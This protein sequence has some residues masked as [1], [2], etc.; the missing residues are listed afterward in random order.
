MSTNEK[1][2]LRGMFVGGFYGFCA[3]G[4]VTVLWFL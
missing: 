4:I 1:A 2:F 3:G